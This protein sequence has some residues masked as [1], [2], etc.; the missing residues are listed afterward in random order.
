MTSAFGI[1]G[2]SAAGDCGGQSARFGVNY[3]GQN[4]GGGNSE[5]KLCPLLQPFL[6][7]SLPEPALVLMPNFENFCCHSFWGLQNCLTAC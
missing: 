6:F 1:H 2:S 5:K 3:G 7:A 4:T